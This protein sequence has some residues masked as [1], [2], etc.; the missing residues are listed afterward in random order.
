MNVATAF[1]W[2]ALVASAVFALIRLPL[3]VKGRNPMLFWA[4]VLTAVGVAISIPSI[5]L[6]FDALLG[7]TNYANLILR[8]AVYG[9]M[10][11]IGSISAA[12]FR[13][14]QARR[15]ILGR[16]G[17]VVLA[18]TA[19]ATTVLFL[20]CDLPVSS[21][22]LYGYPEQ[23]LLWV[24]AMV[25]RIYPAYICACLVVPA[26]RAAAHGR[27]PALLRGGSALIGISLAEVVL[28]SALG[29]TR[30]PIGVWDYVL[31]HSAVILLAIGL[32][33]VGLYG[34]SAGRKEKRSLLTTNPA[35]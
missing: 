6:P 3:A 28:W 9:V 18:V 19:V 12:A 1:Q 20:L 34:M 30:W 29:I 17:L 31:P 13:A 15:L 7:G 23:Y 14:P 2:G 27:R 5:Y 32:G 24:Y 22:G 10:F 21:P 33:C 35:K 4:L 26:F 25:G 8:F 11:M 16:P